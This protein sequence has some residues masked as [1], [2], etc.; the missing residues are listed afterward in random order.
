MALISSGDAP[1]DWLLGCWRLQWA[2]A[3][4][5]ILP[6]TRMDFRL[7]GELIYTITLE[8]RQAMFELE[9]RIEGALLH[10]AYPAGAHAAAARFLL[11]SD[12]RLQFDFGGRRAWFVR[13]RLM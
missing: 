13:E 9:Y 7:D 8:G 5:E 6:D 12:G 1:P 11:E 3:G 10:T 4:L 2:E